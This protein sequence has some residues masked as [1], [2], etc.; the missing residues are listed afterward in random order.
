MSFMGKVNFI[1]LGVSEILFGIDSLIENPKEPKTSLKLSLSI[2]TRLGLLGLNPFGA[3]SE[4]TNNLKGNRNISF[5]SLPKEK[6]KEKPN[7]FST[8]SFMPKSYKKRS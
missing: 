1:L 2:K 7:P 8:S 3:N 6:L 5:G 4:I